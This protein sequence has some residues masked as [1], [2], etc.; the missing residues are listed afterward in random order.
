MS[1]PVNMLISLNIYCL[2]SKI[3]LFPF[4]YI[5]KI[6]DVNALLNQQNQIVIIFA[7]SVVFGL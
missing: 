5:N 3:K 7:I 6:D 4:D 2:Y 1:A